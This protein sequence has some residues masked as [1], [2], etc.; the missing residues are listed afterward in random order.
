MKVVGLVS[1]KGG[2]G[3]STLAIHLADLVAKQ[4]AKVALLDLD[5]QGSCASWRLRR[6]SK[7]V[8]VVRSTH[9]E[10][11]EHLELCAASGIEWVFIDTMP[12]IDATTKAVCDIADYVVVPTRPSVMDLESVVGTLK[13]IS[14]SATPGCAV[15]NLTPARGKEIRGAQRELQKR[16]YTVSPTPIIDRVAYRRAIGFG[17]VAG[18]LDPKAKLEVE[19]TWKFITSQMEACA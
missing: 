6:E 10:L 9:K 18:D 12:D 19:N 13:L 15:F 16:D 7:S 2:V 11:R 4:G 8:L 1:R 3:K 14:R 5:L 17:K